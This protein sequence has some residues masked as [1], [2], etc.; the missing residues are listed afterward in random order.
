MSTSKRVTDHYSNQD[1]NNN[2]PGKMVVP[3]VVEKAL[4]AKD[5]N[6]IQELMNERKGLGNMSEISLESHELS[7]SGSFCTEV[8]HLNLLATT[9]D[10]PT[11]S[12][13]EPRSLNDDTGSNPVID[14]QSD[15]DNTDSDSDHEAPPPKRMQ[16]DEGQKSS[17]TSESSSYLTELRDNVD[18]DAPKDIA[19]IA[20][21]F[22][23]EEVAKRLESFQ[24]GHV[25][26][27]TFLFAHQRHFGI[28][29]IRQLVIFFQY[30][31]YV[32]TR[33]GLKLDLV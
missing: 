31:R 2:H 9:K 8:R 23:P 26:W 16:H 13:P 11:I 3:K 27:C 28:I 1:L 7:L 24:V 15:S 18:K 6:E 20:D 30:L 12:N 4:A 10:M 5:P 19:E 22:T 17:S 32:C 33:P 29:L 25:L 14:I 21:S